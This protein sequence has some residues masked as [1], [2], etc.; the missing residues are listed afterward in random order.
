MFT[1]HCTLPVAKGIREV[2]TRIC[3]YVPSKYEEQ[4]GDLNTPY[5]ETVHQLDVI[6]TTSD[7]GMILTEGKLEV[8]SDF[9]MS[10]RFDSLQVHIEYALRAYYLAACHIVDE[11]QLDDVLVLID[12]I[13]LHDE[14]DGI[15]QYVIKLES[16][17]EID[18]NVF[19]DFKSRLASVNPQ[20]LLLAPEDEINL[21]ALQQVL[22]SFNYDLIR[23]NYLGPIK[24]NR[25][26]T[27]AVYTI[28]TYSV[29]DKQVYVDLRAYVNWPELYQYLAEH[30]LRTQVDEE[31][32]S[33]YLPRALNSIG[34]DFYG[35]T[36]DLPSSLA[37]DGVIKGSHDLLNL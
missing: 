22:D 16:V 25:A 11:L 27:S 24:H 6:D 14:P 35:Q 7:S 30:T 23:H 5:C 13:L 18:D 9:G 2:R 29:R 12:T 32:D 10:T 15:R 36:V 26:Y 3:D 28:G 1:R 21:D 31:M 4:F 8:D 33:I 17:R 34:L 19:A 37:N 20:Y